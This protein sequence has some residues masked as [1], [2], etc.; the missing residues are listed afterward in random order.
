VGIIYIGDRA[1]GKTH[2]ATE[3]ANPSNNRYV[4]VMRPDYDT[5]KV[6]LYGGGDKPKPTPF[7][8]DLREMAVQ[9]RLPSGAKTVAVDWIDTSGEIWR[10]SYQEG[11][12]Q[13][14]K[15]FLNKVRSSEGIL[16]ILPPYRDIVKPDYADDFMT[17]Q[18]WCN[19]FDRWAQFFSYD[20][21]NAKHILIC[22][23]KADLLKSVDLQREGLK[24]AYEPGG[25]QMNWQQRHMYVLN[26]YFRPIQ[27]QLQLI[28]RQVSG[29]SVRCFMT[30][31]HNRSLLELPWIYLGSFLAQ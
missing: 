12:Q 15:D 21:P 4:N 1:T 7:Q 28:N 2:L 18:Q 3:L 27:S 10:P 23:N 26:Q 30:S 13:E 25:T 24:L 16:L 22:L 14:W 19:R 17:R 8:G 20:C 6:E 9:V 29:S 11:N 5:L 31:I